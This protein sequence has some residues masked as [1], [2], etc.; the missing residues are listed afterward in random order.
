MELDNEVIDITKQIDELKARR[1]QIQIDKGIDAITTA[2]HALRRE[3]IKPHEH[4]NVCLHY[5]A[6][7]V[8]RAAD[9]LCDVIYDNTKNEEKVEY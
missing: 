2:A 9:E 1:F 8:R 6:E 4:H 5:L 3:R 7:Q